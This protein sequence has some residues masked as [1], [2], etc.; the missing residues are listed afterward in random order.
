MHSVN[1]LHH[2]V[3]SQKLASIITYVL[4]GGLVIGDTMDWLNENASAMGVLIG[5]ATFLTNIYFQ[6][7]RDRKRVLNDDKPES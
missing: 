1:D 2:G 6:S 7:K 5:L 4:S 3:I